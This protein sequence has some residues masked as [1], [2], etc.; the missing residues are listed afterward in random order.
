MALAGAGIG[1][2]SACGLRPTRGEESV[3]I[4][5][6]YDKKWI[7]FSP[8][9]S[10]VK[11]VETSTVAHSFLRMPG[12]PEQFL[13]VEKSGRSMEIV[14]FS[15]GAVVARIAPAPDHDFYGHAAFSEDRK[16]LYSSQVDTNTGEGSIVEY[17]A[18]TLQPL[19]RHKI[20]SGGVHDLSFVPD[21]S[22]RLIATSSGINHAHAVS[23]RIPTHGRRVEP[24]KLMLYSPTRRKVEREFALPDPSQ[25]FGHLRWISP[26]EMVA[27]SSVFDA[28][29]GEVKARSGSVYRCDLERG[30]TEY[31]IPNRA[32]ERLKGELL[33][34]A[35]DR[36]GKKVLVTNPTGGVLMLLDAESHELLEI[37]PA[38]AS[39]A[40]FA[41]AR[42]AFYV[43]KQES[44]N[45]N[46]SSTEKIF[47]CAELIS[48]AHILCVV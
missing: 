6:G 47:G 38:Q 41:S 36:A 43:S 35:V 48:S 19:H 3:R 25:L 32:K 40:D 5:G 2:P 33:S 4:L 29:D 10:A 30:I 9:E 12:A 11:T 26:T 31:L 1:L 14:D 28:F 17:D 24:S 42:S 13:G 20:A 45:K 15:R 16:L 21:G 39:G 7:L 22:G 18:L 23:G 44:T 8:G 34:L 46:L 27:I 37:I